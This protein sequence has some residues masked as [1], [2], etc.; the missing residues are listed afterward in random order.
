VVSS[1]PRPHFI[2]GK[3]L[4]HILQDAGW[5]P[6]SNR[7]G[8]KSRPHRDSIP[9]FQPVVTILTELPGPTFILLT[10]FKHNWMSSAKVMYTKTSIKDHNF[11]FKYHDVFTRF[12]TCRVPFMLLLSPA[13]EKISREMR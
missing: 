7:T 10:F 8:G 1:T 9:D 3:Y 5:A 6:G 12:V 13:R 2:P 11:A 4:V